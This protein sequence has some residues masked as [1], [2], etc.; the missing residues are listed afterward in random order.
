MVA[1]PAAAAACGGEGGGGVVRLGELVLERELVRTLTGDLEASSRR[2]HELAQENEQLRQQLRASL[3]ASCGEDVGQQQQQADRPPALDN[4]GAGGCSGSSDS[5]GGGVRDELM[6]DALVAQLTAAL[7]DKARLVVANDQ[8]AREVAALRELLTFTSA[9][10]CGTCGDDGDEGYEGQA[11][12]C[13]SPDY[14]ARFWHTG[15]TPERLL[16]LQLEGEGEG[17]G[18]LQQ[19]APAGGGDD[20]CCSSSS[21]GGSAKGVAVELSFGAASWRAPGGEANGAGQDG[22]APGLLAAA[23]CPGGQPHDRP[24]GGPAAAE[25]AGTDALEWELLDGSL[26]ASVASPSPSP[27]HCSPA[28]P[29]RSEAGPPFRLQLQLDRMLPPAS[30][31]GCPSPSRHDSSVGDAHCTLTT[32]PTAMPSPAAAC[33]GAVGGVGA[34]GSPFH[35]PPK[36]LAVAAAGLP[37]AAPMAERTNNMM[38]AGTGW[39]RA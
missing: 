34:C 6:E 4:G 35:Q 1:K 16:L 28:P 18:Q 25:A 9:A 32:L 23:A 26:L 36:A 12:R 22:G 15:H 17:P 13:P 8:L 38:P 33:V 27:S 10:C 11:D 30:A 24:P 31:P 37:A 21:D 2:C 20:G 39:G 19:A 3:A 7:A 29:E 14:V 5:G